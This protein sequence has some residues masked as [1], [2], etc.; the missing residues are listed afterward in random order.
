MYS[1]RCAHI[2]LR[3]FSTRIQ[4]NFENSEELLRILENILR[5]GFLFK[6]VLVFCTAEQI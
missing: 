1:T 5:L 6:N 3:F 4:M 2:N